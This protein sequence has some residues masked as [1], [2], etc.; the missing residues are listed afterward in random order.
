VLIFILTFLGTTA[1]WGFVLWLAT[2][3]VVHHLR[4]NPEGIAALTAHLLVPLLGR[5]EEPKQDDADVPHPEV[6]KPEFV[7]PDGIPPEKAEGDGMPVRKKRG[8]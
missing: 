5:R 7:P 1:L 2:R 3:R 8:F 6:A 4:G